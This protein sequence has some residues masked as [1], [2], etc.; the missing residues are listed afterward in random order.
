MA[1]LDCNEKK[2]NRPLEDFVPNIEKRQAILSR[3]KAPLKDAAAVNSIR[4]AIGNSLKK[5]G[6]P[7]SFWSGG[8]T[9]CNRCKQ[10]YPKEH[11]IDAACIGQSGAKVALNSSARI[12]T[13][14]ADG[15]G[16]RQKCRVNKF[17]FP[18][19]RPKGAK[20]VFG[21]QTGD[22]VKANVTK[23]KK[24]GHYASIIGRVTI[25]SSGRFDIKTFDNISVNIRLLS[26]HHKYCK[27]IQRFAPS[28][29][30]LLVLILK[31]VKATS[32]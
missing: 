13:I 6:V 29:Q 20:R 4:Y 23:G 32:L 7:V 14:K 28:G 10:S 5:L 16:S 22:I 8:R 26:I 3:V 24:A 2:G 12:L 15:R 31:G 1:C 25:R 21:F 30:R 27:L 19:T 11:W 9:K 17:G 18:R